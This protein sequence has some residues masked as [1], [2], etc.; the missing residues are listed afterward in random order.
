M[1]FVL[2]LACRK[3]FAC[4]FAVVC[5]LIRFFMSK[6]AYVVFVFAWRNF[7]SSLFLKACCCVQPNPVKT[8]DSAIDKIVAKM[9]TPEEQK[10]VSFARCCLLWFVVCVFGLVNATICVS[11]VSAKSEWKPRRKHVLRVRSEKRK[12]KTKAKHAQANDQ[13]RADATAMARTVQHRAEGQAAEQGQGGAGLVE[14]R[15]VEV[16]R[17]HAAE[18]G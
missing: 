12:A 15:V 2:R 3:L 16:P 9:L 13:Q 5:L 11:V 18:E 8:M 1:L 14:R 10:T 7:V 6:Y 4:G 17:E